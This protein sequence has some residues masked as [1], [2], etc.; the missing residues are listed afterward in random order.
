[1]LG[2]LAASRLALSWQ[3]YAN[4]RVDAARLRVKVDAWVVGQTRETATPLISVSATNVGKRPTKLTSISLIVGRPRTGWRR[5]VPRLLRRPYLGVLYDHEVEHMNTTLPVD[6]D[7]GDV[8]SVYFRTDVVKER[9][10]GRGRHV[11][12]QAE[13]ATAGGKSAALDVSKV[14]LR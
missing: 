12:G 6:L 13:A 1:S 9:S 11:F 10:R 14:G 5:L 8:A 3:L 4:L 7:V 2:S